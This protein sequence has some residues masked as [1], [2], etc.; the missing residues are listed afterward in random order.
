MNFFN[1]PGFIPLSRRLCRDHVRGSFHPVYSLDLIFL[2]PADFDIL[3][4]WISHCP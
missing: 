1:A 3:T 4:P 2:V